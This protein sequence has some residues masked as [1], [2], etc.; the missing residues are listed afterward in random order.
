[1]SGP[2]AAAP[3]APWKPRAMLGLAALWLATALGWTWPWGVL[4]LALTWNAVRL[5]ETTLVEPVSLRTNPVLFHGITATWVLL[6][7]SLIAWDLARWFAPQW[8]AYL[9]AS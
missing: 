4:F 3:A 7:L 1:M 9:G 5:G 8:L 6:S 2:A